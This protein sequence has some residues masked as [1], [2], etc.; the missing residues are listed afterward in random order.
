MKL[1]DFPATIETIATVGSDEQLIELWLSGKSEN[2]RQAYR[3]D[4][5]YFLQF[6]EG[7]P[8]QQ[9]TLNDFQAYRQAI[10]A[11]GWTES[12]VARRLNAVKSLL[13]YG[14][15]I[16][17]LAVNCALPEKIRKGKD[18]LSQRILPESA[19]LRMLHGFKGSERDRAILWFLYAT[20]CRA[21]EAIALT[22]ADVTEQDQGT[23]RLTIHGKGSKTRVL[24]LATDSWKMV[25][26]LKQG[27]PL[28][29]PVF[30]SRNGRSLSRYQLHRIVKAAAQQ[31]GIE[32]NVS[33]H[34]LR[35][36]HASHALKRGASINL[37]K[38]SLGHSRLDT[39]GIYLHADPSDSSGLYLSI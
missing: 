38:D 3:R 28:S 22:W 4:I 26:L 8:L 9:V 36:A 17:A 32:Q 15:Q 12:T 37:V 23:A 34:W 29:A 18:T 6:I 1:S 7:K 11:L 31:A 13:T 39:T 16:G 27:S 25:K 10:A 24:L 30:R 35:H 2:T 33:A 5:D 20:G 14:H 21:S 19:V